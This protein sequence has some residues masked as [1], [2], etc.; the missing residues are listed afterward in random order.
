MAQA[1]RL[2]GKT[3]VFAC[4][5]FCASPFTVDRTEKSAGREEAT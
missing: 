3:S 1:G 4:D 2:L 5:S